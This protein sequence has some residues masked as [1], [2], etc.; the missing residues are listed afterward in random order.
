MSSG[1]R[2]SN[3]CPAGSGGANPDV[4]YPAASPYVAAVGGSSQ[5]PTGAFGVD[6]WLTGYPPGGEV[7][8]SDSG[9][10]QATAGTT[11]PRPAWQTGPGV[12]AGVNRL[13]PDV[14]MHYGTCTTPTTGRPFLTAAGQFLWLVSGTSADAPLW[15]GYWAVA[16]QVT[17][18]NLGNAAPLMWRILRSEGGT[19][20]ATAFHDIV[21][22]NNGGFAAGAGFDAVTGIGTPR[23]NA[24]YPAL[25]LL[26]GSGALQGTVLAGGSPA[27]G[28]S[29]TASGFAGTYSA[30][31]NGSGFYQFASL[32]PGSYTVTAAAGGY[33]S[34]AAPG[35]TVNNAATT[36]QDFS[37]TTL[38]A[39]SACVTDT[40]QA[41]FTAATATSTAI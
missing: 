11:E 25:S 16:N 40:S 26:T 29:V 1:D 20:Y 23:F 18:A 5:D 14:S 36:T 37:L 15:A 9:G 4:N 22:G 32:P 30:T 27:T 8:C 12:P 2:G 31:A 7:A 21:S 3:D 35:V 10:G 38:A 17:G 28:A 34:S 24:I 19:N 39:T 33:D 6:G 13:V 41:D